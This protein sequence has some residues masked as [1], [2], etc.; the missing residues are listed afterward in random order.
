MLL[1]NSQVKLFG[2]EKLRNKW[3]GPYT[4]INISSNEAITI[5][6]GDGNTFKVNGQCLKIFLEPSHNI[7]QEI[8]MIELI[9][10]DKFILN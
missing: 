2:E 10:F 4:I 7:D 1:F 9:A 3:K 6:D 8:G 5:Q